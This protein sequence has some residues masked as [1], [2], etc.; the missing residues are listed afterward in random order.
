M[1]SATAPSRPFDATRGT[2]RPIGRR[3]EVLQLLR[4]A[5][6]PL[7]IAAIATRLG[8][9]VNTVRFHLDALLADG[10]VE[11]APVVAGATGR[12]AKRFRAA[13]RMDPTGPRHYL[14]LAE[15]LVSSLAN[16]SDPS[17]G[18]LTAGQ[19]WGRRQAGAAD[20]EADSVVRLTRLLDDLDFAPKQTGHHARIELRHCPF[21]ELAV[22]H[23]E[24]VCPIHLGLM[25]GALAAWDSPVTIDRLDTFADPDRCVAH[26]GPTISS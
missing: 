26:L 8:V 14:M 6:E 24:I 13:R 10:L 17:R 15:L 12:P 7:T 9:H 5:Q 25:Q 23:P 21:L 11:P 22:D 16:E 3:Q 1:T 20:V 4:G 2:T 19:A 18:A